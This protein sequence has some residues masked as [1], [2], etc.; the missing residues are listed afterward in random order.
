M[1]ATTRIANLLDFAEREEARAKTLRSINEHDAARECEA[2]AA[3]AREIAA[4]THEK[5]IA[6]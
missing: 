1:T 4:D 2:R 6:C 3:G 5:A